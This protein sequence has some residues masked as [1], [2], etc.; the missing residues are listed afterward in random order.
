MPLNF[1]LIDSLR[2]FQS[3]Y[4]PEFKVECP[5]GSATMLDLGQVADEMTRRL[6]RLFVD[7][8]GATP[9]ALTGTGPA[10]IIEGHL[11]FHEYFDGDTG[12][13]LGASHQTGW[14]ALA[15]ALVQ[16]CAKLRPAGQRGQV[17]S[18]GLFCYRKP[19]TG[20]LVQQSGASSDSESAALILVAVVSVL[21]IPYSVLP[22]VWV[23]RSCP[24]DTFASGPT[25]SAFQ[26]AAGLGGSIT[27]LILI[28]FSFAKNNSGRC[29]TSVKFLNY[30]YEW[31]PLVF[32]A[33]LVCCLL[34]CATSWLGSLRE[35]YCLEPNNLLLHTSMFNSSRLV[36]WDEVKAVQI[37]CGTTRNGSYAG[38][39]ITAP[40]D[41]RLWVPLGRGT[42]RNAAKA[43]SVIRLLREH[44]SRVETTGGI[45][46][47]TC[48][49]S[50]L[51]L[52]SEPT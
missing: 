49:K 43:V 25:Q 7:P 27:V 45:G 15:A 20:A 51:R 13:G 17:L 30:L 18:L 34:I 46:I 1:L 22:M 5:V 24:I 4:G 26:S 19:L 47:A 8:G 14:T 3:Y 40:T 38:F 9:A 29:R 42:G 16:S 31:H 32:R 12:Q 23:G 11:L 41:E 44:G 2:Q 35:Y 37:E 10:G 28:I 33:G 50:F 52:L 39:N 6:L 36:T 48:P 21:A